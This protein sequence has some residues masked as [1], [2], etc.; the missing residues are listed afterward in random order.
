MVHLAMARLA[1]LGA[2]ELVAQGGARLQSRLRAWRW[3][4]VEQEMLTHSAVASLEQHHIRAV[5]IKGAV[6]GRRLFGDPGLRESVDVDLLLAPEH[7]EQAAAVLRTR[8]G[9]GTPR[10]ARYAGGRPN[11]HYRLLHA[12][13]LPTIELHW[14]LHWY[15]D[16]SGYA[17][18]RRAT[19]DDG[20]GRLAPA[21]ELAALLLVY[22]RDGFAGIRPLA[23]L[24]AWWDRYGDQLPTGGLAAF[25][26][27]FPEL[28]PALWVGAILAD[29]L[30]GVP[31]TELGVGSYAT[32]SRVRRAMRLANWQL[33]GVDEQILAD[34]VLV[35]LLLT[36][37]TKAWGFI[38][39]QI[40]LPL[41]VVAD[42]LVDA[43]SPRRRLALAAALHV[44]RILGRLALAMIGT[45]DRWVSRAHPVRRIGGT[46]S[47]AHTTLGHV[48]ESA[49]RADGAR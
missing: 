17:M 1:D 20:L 21:D 48:S 28:A 22:A 6:L 14:R 47:P 13:G 10:G 36:P 41:D 9:Y 40:L 2:E 4:A 46:T 8:F 37:R 34:V 24:A 3:T 23:D 7:L 26:H 25:S 33:A 15:E 49:S 44:P 29:R 18:V 38:R 5:P 43:P 16:R 19:A 35:D 11:L 12:Q 32:K 30:V 39:R 45:S 42:R 31:A 27:E